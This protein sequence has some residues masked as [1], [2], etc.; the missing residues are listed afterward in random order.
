MTN[1]IARSYTDGLYARHKYL[2][3]WLPGTPVR[4][5]DRGTIARHLWAREGAIPEYLLVS[6]TRTGTVMPLI[7]WQST[8]RFA[9]ETKIAGQLA[10]AFSSLAEA[11]S[12]F[13]YTFERGGG[14]LF[15]ATDVIINEISETFAVREWMLEQYQRGQ[16]PVDTLVVTRVLQASSCVI[17][18]SESNK[19]RVEMRTSAAA[20]IAG[21]E[22]ANLYAE[23]VITHSTGM[24]ASLV[25]SEGAT[26]LFG[27]LR[28][29]RNLLRHSR[30]DDL[31]LSRDNEAPGDKRY[32]SSATEDDPF[33][34]V[35]LPE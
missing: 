7:E 16:L 9:L 12:G 22:L 4:I 30:V 18:I 14:I 15:R 20:A 1:D 3:T 33:E 25:L 21:Q 35:G 27:G 32:E 28:I 2:A 34:Q 13:A 23:G 6:G 31:L 5:G 17:L 29:R 11:D 26:P 10:P 19:A 8:A 24:Y